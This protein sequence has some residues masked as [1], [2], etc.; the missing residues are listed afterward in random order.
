MSIVRLGTRGSPLAQAQARQASEALARHGAQ[1][2]LVI[3]STRGDAAPS[4]PLGE[5]G[6]GAFAS[7]L[8]EA[9]LAGD[10]DVAVH[11]SKD[12]TG[13]QPDGLELAAFLQRADPRDAWC[14][15]ARSFGDIPV[16][17]RVGTSSLRRTAALRAARPD[18]TIVPIRGNV[19]TRLDHRAISELDGVILAAAG[20]D[21]IGL[22]HEIG[23]RFPVETIVPESGQGAIA[24]QTRVGD[25]ALVT[26]VDHLDTRA[27]VMAERGVTR[28]LGGGC[29]VPVAAHAQRHAGGWRLIGWVGSPDGIRTIRHES[30]GAN[31]HALVDTIVDRLLQDGGAELL[32]EGGA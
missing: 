16:G 26:A 20:L 25:G 22:D 19:Q 24:L 17:A 30:E 18:L 8:E 13:D 15:E 28:R 29:R 1:V 14:G 32:A 31:P 6:P 11:S 3:V 12:L 10:I 7:A 23:F 5:L 2:E 4:T 21:R 27:A 9:L